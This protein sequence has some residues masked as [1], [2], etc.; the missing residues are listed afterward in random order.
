MKA[1][2]PTGKKAGTYIGKVAI[3]SSGFFNIKTTVISGDKST[4]QGISAKYCKIQQR[5]DG[6]S[7]A[8][9]A[10]TNAEET[11][12]PTHS[13]RVSPKGFSFPP[14][15]DGEGFQEKL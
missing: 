1:V 2:V 5:Q 3:R 7:Y 13:R 15:P 10:S 14:P 6:Y 12:V 8:I 9:L 11:S 4:T